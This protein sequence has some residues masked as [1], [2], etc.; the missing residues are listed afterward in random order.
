MFMI[1]MGWVG[2]V[3]LRGRGED[4]AAPSKES[5]RAP[6]DDATRGAWVEERA[7]APQK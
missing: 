3:T 5:W 4:H 6:E 1:T 2:S 7:I